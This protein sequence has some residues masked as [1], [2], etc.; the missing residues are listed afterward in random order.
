LDS[1]KKDDNLN[2]NSNSKSNN[3][4]NKSQKKNPS[5]NKSIPLNQVQWTKKELELIEPQQNSM[6][7]TMYLSENDEIITP[8]QL[9][10]LIFPSRSQEFLEDQYEQS[11]RNL[12]DTVSRV[13]LLIQKEEEERQQ[14]LEFFFTQPSKKVQSQNE[15]DLAEEILESNEVK[16]KNKN[17][18][19]HFL[20]GLCIRADCWYSHDVS[21]ITCRYWVLGTCLKGDKCGFFHGFEKSEEDNQDHQS[22]EQ[23][24]EKN[25][26]M[27]QQDFPQ[28]I[29]KSS[30]KKKS[31][32]QQENMNIPTISQHKKT[33]EM[34]FANTAKLAKLIKDFPWV[35][36]LIIKE[37][38]QGSGS[39]ETETRFF[40]FF[41]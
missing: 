1:K 18:C 19:R 30:Q 6:D 27:D 38:F 35:D 17:I 33:G 2:L 26:I 39:K 8:L 22:S 12:D 36:Q 20:E 25:F 4:E 15:K 13:I 21:S 7:D 37:I 29:Q 24:Q 31:T 32:S 16:I 34:D 14:A 11:N 10:C 28:L 23:I 9:L 41:H 40:F 3:S 5:K